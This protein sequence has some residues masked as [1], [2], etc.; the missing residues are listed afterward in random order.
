LIL[1]CNHPKPAA[2][3]NGLKRI[4]YPNALKIIYLKITQAISDF[5]GH[6][7]ADFQLK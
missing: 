4:A 2:T 5:A 7:P 3:R 6:A 1:S